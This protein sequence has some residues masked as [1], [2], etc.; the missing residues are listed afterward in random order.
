MVSAIEIESL[1]LIFR[2]PNGESISALRNISLTIAAGE[3]VG[4]L[5]ADGAGKTSLLR[6]IGGQLEPTTGH[7]QVNGQE[8]VLLDEPDKHTGWRTQ[9]QVR[10]Q[11][12]TLLLATP[13]PSLVAELCERV[14]ILEKG[15]LVMDVPASVLQCALSQQHYHIRVRGRLPQDWSDW[16]SGLTVLVEGTDT[17]LD[18]DLLDQGALHNVLNV[19]A[20]LNLPLLSVQ[21]IEPDIATLVDHLGRRPEIPGQP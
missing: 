6:V 4:L 14:M 2:S 11:G 16:F 5:G 12:Q 18:G 1:N 9:A 20:T 13:V 21:Y 17:V 19:I 8:V 10:Q 7:V 3:L 15:Q